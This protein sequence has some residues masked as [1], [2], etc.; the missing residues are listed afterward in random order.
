[1]QFVGRSR[2]F[3]PLDIE[4]ILYSQFRAQLVEQIY[5]QGGFSLSK[6]AELDLHGEQFAWDAEALS[7]RIEDLNL[8]DPAFGSI[9]LNEDTKEGSFLK[10]SYGNKSSFEFSEAE[11]EKNGSR[12][13]VN[14]KDSL[15][16]S[17]GGPLNLQLISKILG[18]IARL[19]GNQFN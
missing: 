8:S 18:L 15:K 6:E 13:F 3:S 1:M 5:S 19:L 12:V 2:G 9:S 16:E 4:T 11:K 7:L 10:I 14:I 17:L